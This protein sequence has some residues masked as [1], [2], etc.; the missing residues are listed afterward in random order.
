MAHVAC[1]CVCVCTTAVFET[2]KAILYTDS[3]VAGEAAGL[4]MGLVMLGTG[5]EAAVQEMVPIS[6][7]TYT[8]A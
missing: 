4:A 3:A 5:K 8:H 7:F 1:A 2:L 6:L